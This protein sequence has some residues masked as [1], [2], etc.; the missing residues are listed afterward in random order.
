MIRVENR[1]GTVEISNNFFAELVSHAASGCFGVAGMVASGAS[2]GFR[3]MAGAELTYKGVLVRAK[4]GALVVDLH[5][6]VS[7]GVNISAVVRSIVSEVRY[8][9]EDTTGFKVD[10]VNVFVDAMKSE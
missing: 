3:Q 1:L 9:V 10:C 8:A 7:Y 4:D 5:I 6:E 2:Q